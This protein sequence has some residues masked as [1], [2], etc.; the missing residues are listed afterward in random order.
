MII[1]YCTSLDA[2]PEPPYSP[3]S[4]SSDDNKLSFEY[5]FGQQYS[6]NISSV[7]GACPICSSKELEPCN[8]ISKNLLMDTIC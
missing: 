4:C 5:L 7:V 2:S 3:G 1:I 6:E 8:N